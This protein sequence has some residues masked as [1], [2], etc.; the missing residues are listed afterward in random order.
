MEFESTDARLA[1][2]ETKIDALLASKSDHETRI[3]AVEKR[4]YWV[5]GAAALL[6]VF[7]P[8][9]KPFIGL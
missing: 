8:Q 5:A 2:I 7:A 4:S 1:R 6:A 9:L 3:R